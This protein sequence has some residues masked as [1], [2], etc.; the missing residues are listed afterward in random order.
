MKIVSGTFVLLSLHIQLIATHKV[1]NHPLRCAKNYPKNGWFVELSQVFP[2]QKL[3]KQKKNARKV[4]DEHLDDELVP[5][6]LQALPTSRPLSIYILGGL[7]DCKMIIRG[8]QT[9]ILMHKPK[10]QSLLH[11]PTNLLFFVCQAWFFLVWLLSQFF[12]LWMGWFWGEFWPAYYTDWNIQGQVYKV[13]CSNIQE[14]LYIIN[15]TLYNVRVF[16]I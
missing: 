16:N 5:F 14:T 6:I 8:C 1:K 7:S 4:D 13:W 11:N 15:N 2:L 12:W 10:S 9:C 3:E